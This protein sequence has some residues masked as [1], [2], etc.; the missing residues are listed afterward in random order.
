MK[1][2][3]GSDKEI[4]EPLY[5]I[6]RKDC[7]YGSGFYL[8]DEFDSA[9]LWAGQYQ[10]G[11]YVNEY[12][13]DLSSLRVK[14]LNHHSNDD[15]LHWAALLCSNR[16]D[17]NTLRERREEIAFL[18]RHYSISLD[19]CD[20]IVGYRADDSYYNYT[21]AFLED[22]L[23]LE[24]LKLAM[25]SGKLGLQYVLHSKQ[26]FDAIVFEKSSRVS[27][28]DRYSLLETK[29]NREFNELMKS[30]TPNMTYLRDIIREHH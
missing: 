9:S 23:P 27:H 1:L 30:R 25:E 22:D 7:D 11:G 8:C 20:V 13:L 24:L 4:N 29:A 3:H 6:G 21:K 19:D 12:Q 16:I 15:I 17:Q 5:G 2:F 18:I 26:A 28:N 10:N 14:W